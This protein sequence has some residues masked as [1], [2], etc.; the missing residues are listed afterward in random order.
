[1]AKSYFTCTL[2]PKT[3]GQKRN[4]T[5]HERVCR[6]IH[7]CSKCDKQFSARRNMQ[8]H[9]KICRGPALDQSDGGLDKKRPVEDAEGDNDP[10]RGRDATPDEEDEIPEDVA[11]QIEQDGTEVTYRA[12]W[13]AIRDY[14][15][16][17][18]VQSVYNIRM[19]YFFIFFILFY[20]FY[21]HLI[22]LTL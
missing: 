18:R 15:H 17:H 6:G 2:C 9:E 19:R 3:F 5:R 13:S 11:N 14:V 22:N 4:L 7:T 1:M 21:L 8:R 20:F 10:K 16:H 12:N